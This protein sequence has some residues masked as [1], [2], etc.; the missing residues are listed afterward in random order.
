[1]KQRVDGKQVPERRLLREEFFWELSKYLKASELYT[2]EV[3]ERTSL[4]FNRV[5]GANFNIDGLRSLTVPMSEYPHLSKFFKGVDSFTVDFESKL[6]LNFM[7]LMHEL[8]TRSFNEEREAERDIQLNNLPLHDPNL[9]SVDIFTIP[10]KKWIIPLRGFENTAY[11]KVTNSGEL[12]YRT[13]IGD[14]FVEITFEED[15]TGRCVAY[16]VRNEEI[17][18]CEDFEPYDLTKYEYGPLPNYGIPYT[19]DGKPKDIQPMKVFKDK[20]VNF[21]ESVK[22]IEKEYQNVQTTA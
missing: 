5:A 12:S 17:E 20:Y 8:N 4:T 22:N 7:L 3:L 9:I 15:V 21:F 19:I 18:I 11:L 16:K 2:G 13:H 14:G 10:G 6:Y 1:M